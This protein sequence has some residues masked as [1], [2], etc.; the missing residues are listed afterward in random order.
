MEGENQKI[1]KQMDPAYF[2]MYYRERNSM[3]VCCPGCGCM[4]NKSNLTRHM[5]SSKCKTR[6]KHIHKVPDFDF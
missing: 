2:T 1:K 6:A 5:K 4:H 3:K